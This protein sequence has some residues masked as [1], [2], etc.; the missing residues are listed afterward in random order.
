MQLYQNSRTQRIKFALEHQKQQPYRQSLLLKR[1]LDEEFYTI[2]FL[3][4]NIQRVIFIP[5][6][7]D[8]EHDEINIHIKSTSFAEKHH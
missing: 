5:P 4:I 6:P 8:P 3:Q 1:H 7:A 2:H